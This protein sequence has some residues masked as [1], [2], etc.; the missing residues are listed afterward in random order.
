[1]KQ[2]FYIKNLLK[3]AYRKNP[4]LMTYPVLSTLSILCELIAMMSLL[5]LSAIA[6]GQG[7]NSADPVVRII[8]FFGIQPTESHLILIFCGLFLTRIVTNV[9]SQNIS[10]KY[11]K[12]VLA[13]LA[14]GAFENIVKHAQLKDI[15]E[16]SIGHFISLAGDESFRAST[17]IIDMHQ[18]LSVG[19]LATFYFGLIA[20]YSPIIALSLLGFLSFSFLLMGGVFKIVHRLGTLQIAQSK[21]AASVF[22]DSL[23]GLR[24]VRSFFAENYVVD[25]YRSRMYAYT[26]TLYKIDFI[27]VL[28]K[29]IPIAILF[30]G[31]ILYITLGYLDAYAQSGSMN[32][33]FVF[34]IVLFLLRFFPIVG[35]GLN[36]FMR[37]ISDAKAGRDVTDV[38]NAVIVSSS[39]TM[40]LKDKIKSIGCKNIYFYYKPAQPIFSAFNFKFEAGKS[41]ALVGPSGVGKSTLFNLLMTLSAPQEGEIL[42]NQVNQKEYQPDSVKNKLILVEQESIIFNDTLENNLK[43][44]LEFSRDEITLACKIACIDEFIDTLPGKLQFPLNYQGQNISGGQRQRI[45]IARAVLRHPDVLLL[46]EVTSALD[47]A[48]K[49]KVVN[50]ILTHFKDK[51]VV[52][53][54]HDPVINDLVD[55]KVELQS[56]NLGRNKNEQIAYA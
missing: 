50:N 21:S 11:G 30:S 20:W 16:K 2:L 17:L 41:Y 14:S 1:M 10:F 38:I 45:G 44:G 43:F 55:V 9:L 29:F 25:A 13:Q 12:R 34:S 56:F 40:P 37:L 19:M 36:I 31:I 7:V 46:D 54:S 15:E 6:T 8:G 53:I 24:T 47:E 35:Q 4:I 51:I 42:I 23:N 26:N 28:I 3:F 49:I 33:A 5:P 27:N 18:L 48:T 32:F 22:L 39:G 52:F